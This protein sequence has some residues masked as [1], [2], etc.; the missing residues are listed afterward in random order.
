MKIKLGIGIAT[1]LIIGLVFS[2]GTITGVKT[3]ATY[4]TDEARDSVIER[5]GPSSP[6]KQALIDPEV[7]IEVEEEAIIP[8]GVVFD[9]EDSGSIN[10]GN[11]PQFY[12]FA[13]ASVFPRLTS[14]AYVIADL[15][16]GQII[17]SKAKNAIY[18][19]ASLS[20]L[21]TAV[22]S[23]ET[24]NQEKETTVSYKATQTYGRQGG[25]SSGQTITLSDLMYPLLLESSNDAAEVFAEYSGRN[26]FLDNM[27]GKAKSIG[28]EFTEFSDP[29]GLSQ[30]NISTAKELLTLV[31]Y[32]NREHPEIFEITKLKNYEN[33]DD[34]WYS[35][36]RFRNDK[37]YLGGKNGYTD[38][39][40]HTLISIFDLPLADS[41]AEQE[42]DENRS[43]VII[44]L[45]GQ[46]TEDDTRDAMLWLLNNVYYR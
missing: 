34:V 24:Q 43:I 3:L 12:K 27:T 5:G 1:A 6:W 31:E 13:E 46:K 17:A 2:Y 36:S 4:L 42:G 38:E 9:R 28:M 29:S 32:V 35:N 20:K 39:A 45:Q 26:A 22:V 18:P 37:N 15:E 10:A 40:I 21:M 33:E 23:L 11:D 25:L 16:S 8:R 44:L 30:Y 41:S 7:E 19:I 14:K